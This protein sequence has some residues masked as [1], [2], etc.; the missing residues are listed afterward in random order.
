MEIGI[1]C[2]SYD[3]IHSEWRYRR[4][5]GRPFVRKK[6]GRSEGRGVAPGLFGDVKVPFLFVD[7]YT[8]AF[9]EAQGKPF[10]MER[11]VTNMKLR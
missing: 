5:K 1:D 2:S 10:L 7:K 6:G 9:W 4:E 11:R 3:A 8:R